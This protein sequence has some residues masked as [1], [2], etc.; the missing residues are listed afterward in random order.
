[1]GTLWRNSRHNL[2]G[3]TYVPYDRIWREKVKR[4]GIGAGDSGM[5][6][7]EVQQG[8]RGRVLLRLYGNG[9]GK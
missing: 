1:M 7:S 5:E 9:N 3:T 8:T 4:V 6:G 2:Q